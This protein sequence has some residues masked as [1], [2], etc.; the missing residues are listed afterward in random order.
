MP[1]LQ[2]WSVH[3]WLSRNR[4]TCDLRN[5]SPARLIPFTVHECTDYWDRNRPS[6]GQMQKLALDFS[7][8]HRK[9]VKGFQG[10]GFA[11]A[12]A[13]TEDDEDEE[14]AST[15]ANPHGLA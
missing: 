13:V 7:D 4:R 9:S 11:Q 2:L 1:K 14:A 6:W 8:G 10:S 3:H 15:S 12:P 5:S